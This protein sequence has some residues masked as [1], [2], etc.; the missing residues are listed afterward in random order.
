MVN[1]LSSGTPASIA[2]KNEEGLEDA[3]IPLAGEFH[4][5]N[6]VMTFA[7]G[8]MRVL[9]D[10]DSCNEALNG[11]PDTVDVPEEENPDELE[12]GEDENEGG[13]SDLFKRKL[14]NPTM[15]KPSHATT[16]SSNKSRILT[17][18]RDAYTKARL[19]IQEGRH[20]TESLFVE[21]EVE[22]S[23]RTGEHFR[24]LF[25]FSTLKNRIESKNN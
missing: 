9:M 25:H 16:S 20:L 12:K 2:F 10:S 3:I 22:D 23:S 5:E 11:S 7:S 13:G 19:A 4:D 14:R 24:L 17:R 18:H 6:H 8:K 1:D 15:A 21:V